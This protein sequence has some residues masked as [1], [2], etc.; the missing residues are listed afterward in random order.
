LRA[1]SRRSEACHTHAQAPTHAGTRAYYRLSPGRMRSAEGSGHTGNV[2]RSI[3]QQVPQVLCR[4][5]TVADGAARWTLLTRLPDRPKAL[6]GRGQSPSNSL[7]SATLPSCQLRGGGG[8][9]RGGRGGGRR[10]GVGPSESRQAPGVSGGGPYGTHLWPTP[11]D[12]CRVPANR[13]MA[14]PK[15]PEHSPKPEKQQ[16]LG[17]P[18]HTAASATA[19][20]ALKLRIPLQHLT[21]R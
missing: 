4:A 15:A 11:T 8:K 10:E 6:H 21:P 13:R 5:S 12:R 18:C 14:P 9:E 19:D 20:I 7:G 1:P 17:A 2:C 3:A 16:R